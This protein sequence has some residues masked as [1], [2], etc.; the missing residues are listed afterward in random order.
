MNDWLDWLM[1]WWPDF[2]SFLQ[3]GKH[4]AYVWG[5]VALTVAALGIEW[6]LLR[7]RSAKLKL[8]MN[9]GLESDR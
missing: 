4:G 2:S 6:A 9:A 1:P 8:A 7:R 3:M 5:S